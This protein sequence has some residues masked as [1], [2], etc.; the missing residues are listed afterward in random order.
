MLFILDAYFTLYN[1]GCMFTQANYIW[2][3][4]LDQ[5]AERKKVLH[6]VVLLC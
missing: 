4:L 5:S 2:I 6:S 1:L 3:E